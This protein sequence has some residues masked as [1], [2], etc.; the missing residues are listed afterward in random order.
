MVRGKVMAW[1]RGLSAEGRMVFP[2]QKTPG[3]LGHLNSSMRLVGVAQLPRDVSGAWAIASDPLGR[4]MDEVTSAS[5]PWASGRPF[6][7]PRLPLSVCWHTASS[8]HCPAG[9]GSTA[10]GIP[11]PL[12]RANFSSP[13]RGRAGSP[14]PSP[15]R[16]RSLSSPVHFTL[17][18]SP[19]QGL[20][21]RWIGSHTT[22]KIQ[23]Q[24]P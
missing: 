7:P 9:P 18:C 22:D 16:G 8:P 10:W 17:N 1:H 2:A 21:L 23:P 19:P 5:L 11:P 24:E 3:K 14:I 13:Q 15:A 12:S 6:L 20:H 4:G